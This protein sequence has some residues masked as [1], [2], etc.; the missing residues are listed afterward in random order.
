MN[1]LF[2]FLFHFSSFLRLKKGSPKM[3]SLEF[4]NFLRPGEPNIFAMAGGRQISIYESL[5]S[6]KL[7]QI[8][9][10]EDPDVRNLIRQREKYQNIFSVTF[11]LVI[12]IRFLVSFSH[13]GYC[14][15]SFNLD[16]V[17]RKKSKS[18]F[19]ILFEKKNSVMKNST[20]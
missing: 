5:E 20:F 19:F 14:C 13:V 17:R 3:W 10:Y 8:M 11:F 1:G 2:Y 7:K 18:F 9:C 6:K 4:N 16:L 15:F 12:F